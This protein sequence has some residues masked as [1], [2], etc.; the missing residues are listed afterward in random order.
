MINW[1]NSVAISTFELSSDPPTMV[2]RPPGPA[3]PTTGAAE[4]W[5][6]RKLLLPVATSESGLRIETRAS[7][8]TCCWDPLEKPARTEP[9]SVIDTLVSWAAGKP[10]C[11]IADVAEASA[12]CVTRPTPGVVP[13]GGNCQG[14][15]LK[16]CGLCAPLVMAIWIPV[17]SPV[18]GSEPVTV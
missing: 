3:V 8:A 12:N 7:G 13:T 15:Q 11:E 18:V 1:V 9:P 14:D 4:L 16:F 17:M 2:P 5:P 6:A 10:S